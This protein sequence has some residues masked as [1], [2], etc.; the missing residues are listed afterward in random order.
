MA[1]G[2]GG[3]YFV[4]WNVIH[5]DIG[6]ERSGEKLWMYIK[7]LRIKILKVELTTFGINE[8]S[9]GVE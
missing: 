1:G 4:A 9:R 7:L 2:M 6:S 3:T 8:L 5:V